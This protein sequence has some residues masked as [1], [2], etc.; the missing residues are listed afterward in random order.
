MMRSDRDKR[1]DTEREID[2]FLSRFDDPA[3]ELSADINSYINDQGS[4]GFD[5]PVPS[6]H[7]DPEPSKAAVSHTFSWKEIAPAEQQESTEIKPSGISADS[8]NNK[9]TIVNNEKLEISFRSCKH[10]CSYVYC[11]FFTYAGNK[12]LIRSE[13]CTFRHHHQ[14]EAR[15]TLHFEERFRNDGSMHYQLRWSCS[16]T[17][18]TQ[19]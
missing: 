15:Q 11:M 6:V 17:C 10:G 5:E 1:T 2:E 14:R 7:D 16:I 9:P 18:R 12:N 8:D 13:S 4:A 3:D 19:S